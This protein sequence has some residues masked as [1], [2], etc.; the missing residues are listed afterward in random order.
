MLLHRKNIDYDKRCK[1][2]LGE[3][4]QAHTEPSASNTIAE[5]T[6][7]CIYLR[8]IDNEQGGH[9]LLNLNTNKIIARRNLTRAVITKNIIQRVHDIAMKEGIPK[10][11]EMHT[12]IPGVHDEVSSDEGEIEQDDD[13]DEMSPDEI[14]ENMN[15]EMG[16]TFVNDGNEENVVDTFEIDEYAEEEENNDIED[17]EEN[18]E[19]LE[20]K[21][22]KIMTS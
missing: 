6:I 10:G 2:A 17:D 8:Y 19:Q 16:D 14:Y 11:I 22:M 21:I 15:T 9:Q 4:V 7:D 13:Y 18:N 3:Y 12:T 1:F 20:L 5:R